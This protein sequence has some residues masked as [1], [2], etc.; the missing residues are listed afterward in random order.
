MPSRTDPVDKHT[1]R[2]PASGA[3][4][5][6]DGDR[7]RVLDHVECGIAVCQSDGFVYANGPLLR[8]LGYASFEALAAQQVSTVTSSALASGSG[9]PRAE[10]WRMADGA[11]LHVEVSVSTM[12]VGEH[13]VRVVVV[14]DLS[15]STRAQAQ[16]QQTERLA[17]IGTLAAGVAQQIN[18]PLAYLMANIEFLAEEIP[19]FLRSLSP[20]VSDEQAAQLNDC[21]GAM[22]D[23]RE[24]AERVARI[25]RD[26]RTL[27]R[28]EDDRS[29]LI[30]LSG[31]LDS[32]CVLVESELK[33]RARLVKVYDA[34][35]PVE[36][37]ASRLSQVFVNLL[38]NAAQ[39]IAEGNVSG[40]DVSVHTF[41]D[42]DGMIGVD[43]TDTGVGMSSAVQA[44]CFDPFYTRKPV[45]QGTGLGLTT[46]LAIVHHMGGT[47][48]VES[49]EGRGSRFR[50]KLPPGVRSAQRKTPISTPPVS[51]HRQRILIVDD[52][53]TLLS[54]LRRALAREVDVTL[55]SSAKDALAVLDE[56]QRFDLVL[57]DI[58]MPEVNG[59][60]LY[61][62]VAQAH[63]AV[64]KRFVFMTGGT[65]SSS[66]QQF[67]D[68]CAQPRLE[69]PFDV[70]ELRR[71]LRA[72]VVTGSG[73]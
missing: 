31:L 2:P 44:R 72:A 60:E 38:L 29:E 49:A 1:S 52:E 16:L 25:V 51:A 65:F 47:I 56:D 63:P 37:N 26:L 39:A 70:R 21:L 7:L 14:R 71:L 34:V 69:K 36:G 54:S 32:A 40:N 53:L 57:C 62:R 9:A 19:P 10:T 73:T 55:A 45:G 5:I 41:M 17:T 22:A 67:I 23:A 3:A 46:C 8:M 20:V 68:T 30:D 58:M 4:R 64:A 35:L 50:V 66:V 42:E 33:S 13:G 11:E 43:V 61:Q 24:G 12:T 28:M 18:N 15:A 59:I 48:T 6:E 27:A